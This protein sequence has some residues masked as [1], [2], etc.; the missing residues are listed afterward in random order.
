MA[1]AYCMFQQC[2]CMHY[3]HRLT[4]WYRT[5][6]TPDYCM[7]FFYASDNVIWIIKRWFTQRRRTPTYLYCKL[8]ACV[9]YILCVCVS[10]NFENCFPCTV[11]QLRS[12]S[13]LCQ[14][15]KMW[16]KSANARRLQSRGCYLDS[17]WDVPVAGM[18]VVS[19]SNVQC[20]IG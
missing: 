18:L 5:D 19:L 14:L 1:R 10:I 11:R 7:H 9:Q 16:Q 2:S 6:T 3:D 17:N 12:I 13:S 8:W 4:L 20:K 15:S